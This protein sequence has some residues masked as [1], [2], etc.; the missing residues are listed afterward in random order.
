MPDPHRVERELPNSWRAACEL[1]S[2]PDHGSDWS[3][4]HAF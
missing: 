1:I 2:I 4:R 3:F